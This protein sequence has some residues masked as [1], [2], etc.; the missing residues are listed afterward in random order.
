MGLTTSQRAAVAYDG[1]LIIFAG[2][3]S[4]KTSTSV[5]KG[6]RILQQR[7]T[8]LG[9]V[10]FT[11]AAAAETQERME[12]A[13]G[14]SGR[15][16]IGA[17]L[18]A[19][20]FNAIT[21]RHYQRHARSALKLMPPPQRAALLRTMLRD[22]ESA[23]QD[24]YIAALDAYQAKVNPTF[25]DLP[26]SQ[27]DFIRSYL[28]KLEAAHAIDLS[29]VMRTCTVQMS[30]GALPCLPVTH[31]VGDEMQDADEVQIEFMLVHSRTGIK[32]TLV[33]DDDQ[34]IYEWRNA[35]GYSG[36]QR[37]ASEASAK[38]IVLQE[39]FRSR[40]EIVARATALI[41]HNDPDRIA[42]NQQA[43][44]GPGGDLAAISCADLEGECRQVARSLAQCG[45]Q[46]L[47]AAVLARTN[48]SLWT[49][50]SALLKEGIAFRR[51]GPSVWETPEAATLLS[52]LRAL[53]SGQTADLMLILT[54]QL[55]SRLATEVAKQ[56]GGEFGALL[57]G[58]VPDLA[59]ATA[60]DKELLLQ[61]AGAAS[62]WKRELASGMYSIVIAEARDYVREI[63]LQQLDGRSR[64]AQRAERILDECTDVLQALD[65]KLSSRL[66]TLQRLQAAAENPNV[67]RLLTMHSSK[68][69]EFDTVYAIGAAEP[70]GGLTGVAAER[71]LFYVA[72]TRAR[73]RFFALYSGGRPL[74]FITEAGLPL[75]GSLPAHTE[76]VAGR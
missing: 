54:T 76:V 74:R 32:T 4:G 1:N 43:V 3:G 40:E 70:E 58:H 28:R 61:L 66:A 50:Q 53:V 2:P 36:L 42:K 63:V 55:D 60:K 59:H 16:R 44:R 33:A 37:F 39:N 35:M 30:S 72:L 52:L 73:E 12:R 62:K 14:G 9:M 45:T 18:I 20:T 68:G 31:L 57:E 22:K 75:R 6:A 8:V 41:A 71:R 7:G 21:L 13:A 17:R 5:A 19:G 56:L 25:D 49:M 47:S 69:L 51:E 11:T 29:T 24:E 46:K 26:P 64:G 48:M 34:T 65:G 10:T 38:T 23:E 15:E 27:A 67:V